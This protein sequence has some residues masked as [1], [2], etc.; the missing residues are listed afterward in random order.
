MRALAEFGDEHP[1]VRIEL[2][3]AVL[4]GAE[5]ALIEGRVDFVIGSLVPGGFIGDPLMQVRFVCAAAPS[6]P[7]HQLGRSLDAR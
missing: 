7:L 4:G 6:H 3:E 1:D 5:E 2:I